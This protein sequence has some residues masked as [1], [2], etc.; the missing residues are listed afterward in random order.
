MRDSKFDVI[1]ADPPWS[2]STKLGTM[3]IDSTHG[4]YETMSLD[5]LCSLRVADVVAPNAILFMWTTG[6]QLV[7]SLKLM[8][9][10]GFTYKTMAF[11]WDKEL[12]NPGF[13]TRSQYEYVILG[14][15]GKRPKR[16]DATIRQKIVSKR[17]KHSA[18][19][20]LIQDAIERL[21]PETNKLELFA[22]RHRQGWTCLGNE[23]SGLDI[24]EELQNLKE[25]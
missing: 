22:R 13:Y 3:R 23:L 2:Y 21:Y 9:A 14:K 4:Q 5:D 8:E 15:R 7:A 1:I 12:T 20:E 18:K 6:P 19:P 17:G 10:W 16:G 11:V 25:D 24:R